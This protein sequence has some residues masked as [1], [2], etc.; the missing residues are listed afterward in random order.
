MRSL[1]ILS[2]TFVLMVAMLWVALREPS[3]SETRQE[4]ETPEKTIVTDPEIGERKNPK[5]M[6]EPQRDDFTVVTAPGEWIVTNGIEKASGE[7]VFTSM[8]ADPIWDSSYG[9]ISVSIERIEISPNGTVTTVKFPKMLGQSGSPIEFRNIVESTDQIF[10]GH[11]IT[12]VAD[13]EGDD[14]TLTGSTIE[15]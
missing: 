15:Y 2:V 12:V 3:I 5:R 11:S 7:M 6:A 8:S 4:T 13:Y 9:D 14:T 10:G 1:F